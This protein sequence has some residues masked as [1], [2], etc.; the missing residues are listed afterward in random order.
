MVPIPG[1]SPQIVVGLPIVLFMLIVALGQPYFGALSER[2]G[3][4]RTM[5]YGAVIS[6]VGFAT[7]ALSVTVFD[8]LLWRSLCAL[9]YA[10]VFVS[11][12]GLIRCV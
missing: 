12:Q 10:L 3:H 11:A 6:A 1:L 9:G 7:T 2:S 4:R 5:I 8:L